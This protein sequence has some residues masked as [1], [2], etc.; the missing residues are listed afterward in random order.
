MAPNDPRIEFRPGLKVRQKL[1]ELRHELSKRA[2]REI[3]ISELVS[4]IVGQFLLE[5]EK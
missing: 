1:E 2:G 5:E 4:A 3:S